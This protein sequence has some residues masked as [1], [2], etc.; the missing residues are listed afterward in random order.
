[1]VRQFEET[2]MNR[3]RLSFVVL[4]QDRSCRT[5]GVVLILAVLFVSTETRLGR[6]TC[7]TKIGFWHF[8]LETK[9]YI[10]AKA[11]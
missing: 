6:L 8:S 11:I 1:M 4:I 5:N 9:L 2:E 7:R 10:S 3:I